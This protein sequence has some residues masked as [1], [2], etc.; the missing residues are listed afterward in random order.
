MMNGEPELDATRVV[1]RR[2]RLLRCPYVQTNVR[3]PVPIDQRLNELLDLLN[4]AGMD[5]TRSQLLAALVAMAP[6]NLSELQR[7]LQDYGETSA[8]AVV[9]QARG[10]IEVPAR[11]P[12]RRPRS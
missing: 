1:P 4:A 5:C 6:A 9:L 8:G 10:G 12:G 3:W 2:E 7:L 11:R